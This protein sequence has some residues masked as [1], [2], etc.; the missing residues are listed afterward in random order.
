MFKSNYILNKKIIV[1]FILLYF[2]I[3][4]FFLTKF[5][6]VHSDEPW[7]SGLSRNILEKSSFSVTE[8][9]F[10]LYER[11]PHAIKS[12]FHLI[13]ICFLK[14]F[15]YSV[16]TFRLI[17][18]IFG[19]LSLWFFYKLCS[20]LF[21]STNIAFFITFLLA[22]DIQFI[23]ASHFARQ[24]IL[25]TFVLILGLYIFYKNFYKNFDNNKYYKDV[26]I[27]VLIGLSIGIHPNSFIISLPIGLIYLYHILITKKINIKSLLIYVFIVSLFAGFFV[28]LSFKFDPNF[29][30][31]Y[32][33]Y[34]NQFG[35][36]NP[37][38]SKIK[39]IKDFYLKLY[40]GISGTY[41][42][43]N[44]KFQF[45]LFSIVLLTSI[46]NIFSPKDIRKKHNIIS[47]ILAIIAINIGIIIIGRYNATSLIF[48]FPLF[49]ILIGYTI[50]MVKWKYLYSTLITIVII[51]TTFININPYVGSNYNNYL[52]EIGKFIE[53]DNTVLAN[54][55]AEY[56]FDNGKLHDYR[57]LTFLDENDM[58]FSDYIYSNNM[59]YIVY[60]EELDFIYNT[61]PLWNGIYGNLYFYYDDMQNFL[62]NRC[63][64]IYK[65]KDNFYGI[66][67]ARYIDKKD[68]WIKVY[69]V[70]K[71]Q[72]K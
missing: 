64:L 57:N 3:N 17:S 52:S 36:M 41:Y 62:N 35:V 51:F 15:G 29:L 53:K 37:V 9:F 1:G 69:K 28:F 20:L 4:L 40:Y 63:T 72:Q 39:Q 10:D 32:T 58:N 42:T 6:F 34:G 30:N 8:T 7:L 50:Q 59:E 70:N 49:Y 13:Q 23:Y 55:N 65:F 46:L 60:S 16:F 33:S 56:Y 31:N 68:W 48:L 71:I 47:I 66:R 26:A 25:L 45:Y 19:T 22:L 67:I 61:R 18:L 24:E 2:I 5:P 27:G 21:K 43:P 12:L 14:L 44:I 54:L 11:N 38:S